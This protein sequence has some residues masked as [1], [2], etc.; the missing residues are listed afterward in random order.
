MSKVE[1][2]STELKEIKEITSSASYRC[3]VKVKASKFSVGD[4][5]VKKTLSNI[6]K[7]DNPINETIT[8]ELME[9]SIL[10]QR[11][12]VIS[13]NEAT[14]TAFLKQI[15]LDG[16]LDSEMLF[17][18]DV[19]NLS[20]WNKFDFYEVDSQFTDCTIFGENFDVST[21]LKEEDE[22]RR[23]IVALNAKNSTHL[24]TLRQVNEFIKTLRNG[25]TFYFHGAT[26][27]DFF[28]NE[29]VRFIFRAA[30]RYTLASRR[31]VGDWEFENHS[32]K[33]LNSKHVYCVRSTDGDLLRSV[34]LIGKVIY[35]DKPLS[36]SENETI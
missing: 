10:P 12:K 27:K 22:R 30:R 2:T 1:L 17:S 3:L 14:N 29:S 7:D 4:F 23:R 6:S 21:I 35:L 25:Q 11:Y 36:L 13:V 18:T 24:H 8:T 33:T 5:L 20:S 26:Q 28:S 19:E 34:S 31:G 9:N 32:E 16:K 15:D